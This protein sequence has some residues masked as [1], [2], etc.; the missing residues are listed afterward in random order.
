MEFHVECPLKYRMEPQ[1]LSGEELEISQ[2]TLHLASH[3][4]HIVNNVKPTSLILLHHHWKNDPPNTSPSASK[5][6]SHVSDQ[7][8]G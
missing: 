6:F 2:E 5:N 7:V 1:F 8:R 4:V 3:G